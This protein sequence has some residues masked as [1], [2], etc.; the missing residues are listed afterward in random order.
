MAASIRARAVIRVFALLAANI[1][2]IA[3]R[4]GTIYDPVARFAAVMATTDHDCF[5]RPVH[6]YGDTPIKDVT[7]P[8]VLFAPYLGIFTILHNTAI[9]LG[10]MSESR[11]QQKAAEFFAADAS[12]AISQNRFI[13]IFRQM[14]FHPCRQIAKIADVWQNGIAKMADL[15]FIVIARVDNNRILTLHGL[16]KIFWLQVLSGQHAR[17]DIIP[18]FEGCLLYTSDAADE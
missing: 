17:I 3:F 2:P 6:R 15:R 11:P 10:D 18:Q 7:F 14:L 1:L 4:I 9:E 12:R 8:V 13:F 5:S 16:Q